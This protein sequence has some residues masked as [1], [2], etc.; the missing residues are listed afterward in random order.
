METGKMGKLGKRKKVVYTVVMICFLF[1]LLSLMRGYNKSKNSTMV[2]GGVLYDQAINYEDQ[3][4]HIENDKTVNDVEKYFRPSNLPVL[5]DRFTGSFISQY[6]DKKESEIELPKNLLQTPEDT[7]LNYFSVLRE[8]ANPV[9]G[10][11]AGC[12][13]LGEAT[14]PYPIAYNFLSE[15]YQKQLSFQQYLETF[16]NILHISL[17]KYR[18][19]PLYENPNNIQRYF[20]ELET[21]EGSETNKA[22]FAYYYGF[23]DLIQE[24]ER[25]K[26]SNLEFY[27]ENYLCAP[28]HGWAYDAELSVQ[29]RYGGWCKLI[30]EFY[31]TTQK[32]YVKNVLFMGTDGK[33]YNIV[34]YQLT[35]DTDIEIAQYEKDSNNRWKLIHFNPEDCLKKES[36]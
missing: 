2:M 30:K 3:T 11:G 16:H 13:T 21:I 5:N 14:L 23:V 8:A 26:I 19:V 29:V 17:I 28:Y 12:G 24:G 9:K 15:E 6:F 32:G 31:S 20:V 10:K 27:Q 7:I 22:V 34:F 33:E 35:N 25:F 36:D 1:A 18:Q 4:K